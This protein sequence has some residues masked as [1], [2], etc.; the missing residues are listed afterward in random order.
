MNPDEIFH[1]LEEAGNDYADKE[2]AASLLEETKS[3]VL[4]QLKTTSMEKSDAARETQAKAMRAYREHIG[5]MVE[6]R[7][8]ANKAKVLYRSI[9]SWL[10]FVRTKEATERA[11]MTLR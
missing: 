7:R 6:A 10:D 11:K 2:A 5:Q 4:A 3:I 1:K 9:Q 8:D